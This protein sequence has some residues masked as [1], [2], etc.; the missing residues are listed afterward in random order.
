MLLCEIKH[1]RPQLFKGSP[2]HAPTGI[3]SL[4]AF[5]D[6]FVELERGVNNNTQVSLL[7][8][9]LQLSTTEH[10]YWSVGHH[11]FGTDSK[12]LALGGIAA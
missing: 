9:V 10:V 12:R 4:G 6:M 8:G 5:V 3:C 2:Y 1:C 11:L 7:V